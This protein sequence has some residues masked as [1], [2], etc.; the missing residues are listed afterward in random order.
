MPVGTAVDGRLEQVGELVR[1][2]SAHIVV[3]YTFDLRG[4]RLTPQL[5]PNV[6][7]GA[8]HRFAAYRLKG[9]GSGTVS[10]KEPSGA[11]QDRSLGDQE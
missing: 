8:E 4:N 2:E 6:S 5:A 7:A 1:V 11:G 10:M 3:G 9:M